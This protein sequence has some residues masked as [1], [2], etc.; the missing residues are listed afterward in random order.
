MYIHTYPCGIYWVKSC[1]IYWVKNTGIHKTN[2]TNPVPQLRPTVA[3]ISTHAPMESVSAWAKCAMARTTA[4]MILMSVD[5]VSWLRK[6]TGQNY[7]SIQKVQQN[8]HF[9]PSLLF[10]WT[11]FVFLFRFTNKLYKQQRWLFTQVFQNSQWYILF[12]SARL[13]VTGGQTHV[14]RYISQIPRLPLNIVP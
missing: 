12:L 7:S 13:P 6:I 11:Q 2:L 1:G 5:A 4:M 9:M 10:L 14:W 3:L 8:Y